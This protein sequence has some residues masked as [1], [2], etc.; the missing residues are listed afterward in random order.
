MFII[1]ASRLAD[2]VFASDMVMS[3][4]VSIAQSAEDGIGIAKLDNNQAMVSS[5]LSSLVILIQT[6]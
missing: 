4:A 6:V 5:I 1:D 3:C 2:D